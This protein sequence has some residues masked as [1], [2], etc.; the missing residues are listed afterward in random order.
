M[1]DVLEKCNSYQCAYDRL[2]YTT[3][4][5][6]VFFILSGL[7]GNEGAVITRDPEGLV[8]VRT[9]SESQWFLV[10]TNQ[11]HFKGDCRKRCWWARYN[12]LRIGQASINPERLY[13][14]VITVWPNT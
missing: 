11:D 3:L 13:N 8:N 10:Q 6:P 14:E 2:L 9:L 7:S 4:T 1:R 5:T 12:F